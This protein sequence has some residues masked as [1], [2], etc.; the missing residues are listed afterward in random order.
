[1]AATYR[2]RWICRVEKL[3]PSGVFVD[4]ASR[5]D[6]VGDTPT[7]AGQNLVEKLGE[8]SRDWSAKARAFLEASGGA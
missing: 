4:A 7:E 3:S 6:G 1:M 2:I 8:Q 5:V